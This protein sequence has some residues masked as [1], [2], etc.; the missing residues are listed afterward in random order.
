MNKNFVFAPA[1]VMALL[2]GTTML[3]AQETDTRSVSASVSGALQGDT[4]F[5]TGGQVQVTGVGQGGVTLTRNNA[6]IN[7][8]AGSSANVPSDTATT[9]GV[10]TSGSSMITTFDFNRDVNTSG[11]LVGIGTLVAQGE[12]LGGVGVVGSANANAT[13]AGTT[14]I[15]STPVSGSSSTPT[16][17]QGSLVGNFSTANTMQLVGTGSLFAG[18]QAL[19][20]GERNMGA[21]AGRTGTIS[22]NATSIDLATMAF[23][24]TPTDD[25]AFA[26]NE[27]GVLIN[28]AGQELTALYSGG[29]LLST[30]PASGA[31][32][33]AYNA[34]LAARVPVTNIGTLAPSNVTGNGAGFWMSPSLTN[35][36]IS[37]NAANAG[38]GTVNITASTGGFFGQGTTFG[39]TAA[40]TFSNTGFFRTPAP[41]S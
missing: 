21:A 29:V 40:P 27:D 35:N 24:P 30:P 5:L 41:A 13:R 23:A 26:A 2:L 32:L 6:A 22:A 8:I 34:A 14:T 16:S 7:V 11:A 28:A 18:S 31:S 17:A 3:H 25:S 20:L 12:S 1:A 33:D 36:T 4:G 38:N 9:T 19:N 37:L 10:P 15:N 39:A